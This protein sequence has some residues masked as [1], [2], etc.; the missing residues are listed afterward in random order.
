MP[1]VMVLGKPNGADGIVVEARAEHP[2]ARHPDVVANA[3]FI[4]RQLRRV[5][6][7]EVL[8]AAQLALEV[9]RGHVAQALAAVDPH[10]GVRFAGREV[11]LEHRDVA[12]VREVQPVDAHRAEAQHV[13]GDA[14]AVR[15]VGEEVVEREAG[16]A[17]HVLRGEWRG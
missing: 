8:F 9:R 7:V 12:A 16:G 6:A 4:D 17:R 2:P 14:E 3:K 1:V 15:R 10:D 13:V 11:E 5:A